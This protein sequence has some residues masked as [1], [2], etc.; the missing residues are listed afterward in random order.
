MA[1]AKSL[2][3]AGMALGAWGA[4]QAT[5]AG[6]AMAAGGLARDIINGIATAGRLGDGL[7][8]H[9]TAYLVVYQA[10]IVLLFATLVAIGPLVRKAGSRLAENES[11]GLAELPG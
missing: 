6:L 7:N 4:V 1:L 5:A 3:H 10:E 9:A 8:H 11:L 2:S